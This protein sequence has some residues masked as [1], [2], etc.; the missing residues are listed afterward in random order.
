MLKS[1]KRKPKELRMIDWIKN[2]AALRQ[3]LKSR[4]VLVRKR[5]LYW[6][7]VELYNRTS[8]QINYC[9]KQIMYLLGITDG[10]D[11]VEGE[12]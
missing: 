3:L 6:D 7:D 4:A 11:L 1:V 9:N 5:T 12:E 10:Q 2:T 8:G